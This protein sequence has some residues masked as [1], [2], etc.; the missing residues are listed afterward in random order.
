MSLEGDMT[1][2]RCDDPN[3]EICLADT[4]KLRG[5]MAICKHHDYRLECSECVHYCNNCSKRLSDY[6]YNNGHVCVLPKQKSPE[7]SAS[8]NR[9]TL[10]TN[11][12]ER[13]GIQL[14]TG[15]IRYFPDALAEVARVSVAGSKQ[16]HPDEPVH[17][18]REKSDDHLD[19]IARHLWDA[20]TR[21]IDGQRHTAKV[22]WRALAAL[23]IEIEKE[24]K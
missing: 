13:K 24:Q 18:D 9:Q 14:Y 2:I 6:Q 8:A 3:C 12:T 10:P 11:A 4:A 21:D 15:L 19:C 22:A 16:H 7:L 23:Q 17:W 20:G 5:Y 1:I